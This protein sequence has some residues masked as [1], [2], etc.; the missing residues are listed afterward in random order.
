MIRRDHKPQDLRIA[1][2]RDSGV[3]HSN[4][5]KLFSITITHDQQLTA[6][7]GTQ[8]SFNT[9]Y[10][11]VPTAVCR[12]QQGLVGHAISNVAIA[13]ASDILLV[14]AVQPAEM[15]FDGSVAYRSTTP[16]ATRPSL[17]L[18]PAY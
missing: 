8:R 3:N 1:R 12:T 13:A 7:G 11:S 18:Q 14:F 9:P 10:S 5:P 2:I 17:E 6:L 15:P 16:I 4:A